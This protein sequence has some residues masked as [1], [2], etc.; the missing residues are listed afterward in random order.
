MLLSKLWSGLVNK[1]IKYVRHKLKTTQL[2]LVFFNVLVTIRDS[3]QNKEIIF[4]A[5]NTVQQIVYY[6]TYRQ[7]TEDVSYVCCGVSLKL[8]TRYLCDEMKYV[9]LTSY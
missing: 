9:L 2:L 3:P 1:T 4:R 7:S 6:I 8:N 5:K